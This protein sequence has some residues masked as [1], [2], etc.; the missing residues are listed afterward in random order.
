MTPKGPSELGTKL[1]LAVIITLLIFYFVG[2]LSLLG[3]LD[4]QVRQSIFQKMGVPEN[5]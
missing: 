3:K 4:Q 5:K 1:Q 2:A